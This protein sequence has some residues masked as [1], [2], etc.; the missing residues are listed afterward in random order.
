MRC[1]MAHR[2]RH[3]LKVAICL[4]SLSSAVAPLG[5]AIA[6]AS[7]CIAPPTAA[8]SGRFGY[9]TRGARCEGL[10]KR[11]FGRGD[12]IEI[13]GYTSGTYRLTAP[14][15]ELAVQFSSARPDTLTIRAMSVTSL[16]RYQMD[17]SV[18]EGQVIRWPLELLFEAKADQQ[19]QLDLSTLAIVGCTNKCAIRSDTVYFPVAMHSGV[20][21][22]PGTLALKLRA[23]VN[24]ID[25]RA[26]LTGSASARPV[27]LVPDIAALGPDSLTTFILPSNI[28][29]GEYRL[30]VRAR[31]SSKARWM[32]TLV[33][34]VVVPELR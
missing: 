5:T 17:A 19:I 15:V 4:A 29:P 22:V 7:P 26:S 9:A 8:M 3:H 14:E 18:K 20:G 1:P 6:Q 33:A 31:N 10:L 28:V 16:S 12:D 34:R 23:D 2:F 27:D 13:V 11:Y 21:P 32:S 30:E 25:I 24:A